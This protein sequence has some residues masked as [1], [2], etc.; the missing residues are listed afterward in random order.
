MLLILPR[1]AYR[2]AAGPATALLALDQGSVTCQL[3]WFRCQVGWLAP[4]Q[5]QL[6]VLGSHLVLERYGSWLW[7]WLINT[8]LLI[9]LAVTAMLMRW[10]K[11]GLGRFL[12][13]AWLL[14]L[15]PNLVVLQ[16]WDWDNTK[17]LVWWAMPAS[18]LAGM[19]LVQLGRRGIA[20]GALAALLLA[21]Q[22]AAGALDLDRAWQTRLN[23]PQLRFLDNDELAVAAWARSQTPV[24]AV[25]LTGWQ[26]NHPI[27]TMSQRV[28]VMG[29]R[30]WLWSWGVN[31]EARQRD[32]EA[33]FRGD[34][35]SSELMRKYG[36]GYVVIGP[37]ERHEVGA[38][39]SYFEQRYALAYRSPQG[40]YEVFEV[41]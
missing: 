1:A 8:G 15:V 17:W 23:Q 31:Y 25:F 20:L 7:F 21:G 26:H 29:Y 24:G 28:E 30:G 5:T 32:V 36:V 10:G 9:L 6:N 3:G 27:L 22:V 40:E 2:Q 34:A 14:F 41:A 35:R 4:A 39:A 13:P 11:P 12:L 19:V 16:P 38:N 37:N 18:M 33:M